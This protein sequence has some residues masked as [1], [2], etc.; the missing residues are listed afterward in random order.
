[1][2][3]DATRSRLIP[4]IVIAAFV[5]TA[6]AH[7]Q[8]GTSAGVP[9]SVVARERAAEGL[10]GAVVRARRLLPRLG[11]DSARTLHSLILEAV[12][13]GSHADR[14]E[15]RIS[16]ET[17]QVNA[18]A[19]VQ[20]TGLLH[21]ALAPSGV[22]YR[23]YGR[24]GFQFQPLASF[25]RVN[26]ALGAGHRERAAQLAR[27]LLARATA[28]NGTLRWRYYFDAYGAREPWISGLTQAVAAQ[29]LARVGRIAEA[30]RAFEALYRKLVLQLPQGPWLRLYSF[31]DTAVLNAQLQGIVS[32]REYGIRAAD[33]RAMRL[34]AQLADTAVKL[35]PRFETS[36]WSRYSLDGAGA[37]LAYHR[38]VTSLLWKIARTSPDRVW[39]RTARKFRYEWRQPPQLTARRASRV[40]FVGPAGNHRARLAFRLSKPAYVT[41][42]VGTAST[43]RW[44][45][46]GLH[47]LTW[48][49]G[50][51][52]P[53][54]ASIA[55]G[56]TDYAGN[57]TVRTLPQ[58]TVR[59][60][61][62]GP[63]LHLGSISGGTTWSARDSLSP[64]LRVLLAWQT[65]TGW[66]TTREIPSQ[67]SGVIFER[68]VG[69]SPAWLVV[70]DESGNLSLSR[71]GRSD[72]A[73]PKELL[74]GLL[75]ARKAPLASLL[76]WHR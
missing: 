63:T 35:L 31:S 33:R 22:V 23:N 50:R 34:S 25:G 15:I 10:R 41:V 5:F 43:T 1:L 44:Q 60:D 6:A 71:L 48:R 13:A 65:K 16:T 49:P 11:P 40:V 76:T 45:Q 75:P 26:A 74:Q 68:A 20:G 21:D 66:H 47:L 58:V 57:T 19:L 62:R 9:A 18:R 52:A 12:E 73:P 64:P 30:R 2:H 61:T 32:L 69:E 17:L 54:L 59:R 7:A 24:H 8:G 36:Y 29:A 4:L 72:V 27:A 3:G 39:L 38:F 28:G 56:A 55:V 14:T 51:D 46:P 67:S 53:P 42:R 37:P 70:A